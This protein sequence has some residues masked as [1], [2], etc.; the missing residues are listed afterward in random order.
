MATNAKT[1]LDY[2]PSYLAAT[3]AGALVFLL[4]IVTLSPTTAMWDTSEYIAAA[5][6]LGLPHPPGNP[7]FVLLGRVV[8]LLPI[9][10][11]VAMRINVFAA[12]CSAVSAAMW[13]LITERVLVSWF[14]EH[15]RRIVGA[16]IATLIGATAF[17]VWN[18]SVVNEKVYTI[19]LCGIAIISWLMVRW[20]D[21][22]DAPKSDRLIYLVAYLLGLGYANHM[23]GMLAAPAVGLVIIVRRPRYL[24]RWK[25]ILVSLL[26]L[27]FGITPFATQPIRSAF[28]PPMN[29]GEPTACT[30]GLHWDCTFSKGTYDAFMYNFNRGQYGKPALTDRQA[31]FVQ[32]QVGMW[33]WYFKWQWMRDA[34]DNHPG[35]QSLLAAIF[36][37]LGL[38]GAWVHYKRDRR[39]WW[40]FASL[41]FTVTLCLIYYLNFKYGATQSPELG[42]SVAREVRDR[43]YFFIWSFSPWGVW[44]ALGLMFVWESLGSLF[45]TEKVKLGREVVDMPT[46]NG[47]ALGAPVLLVA[48][49]PLFANWQWASRAGQTDTRDFAEDMLNSVEPYGVLVVV[50]DNDTFP[51][52]F[53][54]DVLGVR[55]DVV[56][57]NTSLLNTDW[58]VR[59]LI[60]RPVY[61][62][63][64]AAGPAIYRNQ[65]WPKPSRGPLNMTMQEA[66]AVPDYVAI[67][68]TTT[69]NLGPIQATIDPKN[70]M[71]D[72]SGTGYLDRASVFVLRMIADSYT[73]RPIYLSRTSGPL[74]AQLGLA[75][76]T[77]TQ[78]LAD[79][80]FIPTKNMG[81]DTV[82]V[83]GAGFMDVRRTLALWDSVFRAPASLA[84]RNGWVD[85]PSIGIPYLYIATGVELAQVLQATG[86]ATEVPR[87][88]TDTRNIINALNLQSQFPSLEAPPPLPAIPSGDSAVGKPVRK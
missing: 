68:H 77:L 38:F 3:I 10:G 44:A 36:L 52:W 70:L 79:K 20:A 22:P 59:Q 41:M 8:S 63:N 78:G 76:N 11:S 37:V 34:L 56:V 75:D 46:R 26:L 87:V 45:G 5:Y 15:W 33:W 48:I 2:R 1:D 29:E 30:H 7:L 51:L 58:Y 65:D 42:N 57:A 53:A 16:S 84:R 12:A 32:G 50:G 14:A 6:T 69:Y 85:Q 27:G 35:A 25:L 47:W 39:S 54:Q 64:K 74:P 81:A 73:Q 82:K 88:M 80:I 83:E 61:D 43:D 40:Y 23:A 28:F 31:P 71:Q 13:F 4:Y 21:D 17:T 18:Q 62:Y 72:G 66:N 67:P 24:L 86:H 19:S 49:I 55:K 9:A 60:R